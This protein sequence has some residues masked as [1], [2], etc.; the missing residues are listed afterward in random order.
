MLQAD[1]RVLLF[2]VRRKN[3]TKLLV[4]ILIAWQL[5]SGFCLTHLMLCDCDIK[6]KYFIVVYFK[7]APQRDSWLKV[8]APNL[9][10]LK[11]YD[12]LRIEIFNIFVRQFGFI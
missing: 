5:L 4:T 11:V 10:E 6:E 2:R 3:W 8:S 9:L 7:M 12:S 1:E